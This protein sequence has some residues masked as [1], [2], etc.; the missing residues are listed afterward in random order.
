M[1]SGF[2]SYVKANFPTAYDRAVDKTYPKVVQRIDDRDHA[3]RLVADEVDRAKMNWAHIAIAQLVKEGY[4]DRVLTTNFDRL[5]A[6]G[7][8]MVGEFPA[9]YDFAAS[10]T[11]HPEHVPDKA[12]FH[13]H[14]QRTGFKLMITPEDVASHA[15]RLR[16][17]MDNTGQGRTWVVVGYSGENDGV[18]D[19]L[20]AAPHFGSG[21]YWAGYKDAEPA[22]HVK[23][24]LLDQDKDAYLVRGFDADRFFIKLAGKLDCFPRLSRTSPLPM[25]R[26]FSR[27]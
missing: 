2:V 24:A 6:Q 11:F 5:V 4:V 8:A 21:L 12:I 27:P 14:G 3:A 22:A 13:L 15:N 20:A 9:V 19:N 7:C 26:S 23:S 1:A 16:S 18:F 25:W 17:V 10:Q